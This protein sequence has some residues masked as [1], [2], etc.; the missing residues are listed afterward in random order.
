MNA[1]ITYLVKI[2]LVKFCLPSTVCK[3]ECEKQVTVLERRPVNNPSDRKKFPQAFN[4]RYTLGHVND[5]L[6]IYSDFLAF[7]DTNSLKEATEKVLKETPD[8]WETIDLSSDWDSVI[9]SMKIVRDFMERV[10][11]GVESNGSPDLVKSLK[12]CTAKIRTK[13]DDAKQIC[14]F[15]AEP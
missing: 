3:S 14:L 7:Q 13:I 12:K 8:S 10:A 9:A 2:G 6:S 15:I 5:N 1:L 4:A 11:S